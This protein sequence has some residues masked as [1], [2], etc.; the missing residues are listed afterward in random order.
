VAASAADLSGNRRNKCM[1]A[2]LRDGSWTVSLSITKR[3]RRIP[4]ACTHALE[5]SA[6]VIGLW[7]LDVKLAYVGIGLGFLALLSIVWPPAG[8]LLERLLIW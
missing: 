5:L 4:A 6:F 3:L 7:K 2:Q 1:T 8:G